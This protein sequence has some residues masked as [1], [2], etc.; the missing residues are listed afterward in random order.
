MSNYMT[1]RKIIQIIF[2][3]IVKGRE[4]LENEYSSKR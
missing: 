1:S 3:H 4:K 2:N